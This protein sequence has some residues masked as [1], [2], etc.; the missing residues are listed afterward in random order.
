M[1]GNESTQSFSRIFYIC[2]MHLYHLTKEKYLG[3]ILKLGL[4]PCKKYGLTLKIDKRN[5]TKVF[6]TNNIS[7][8][9]KNHAGDTWCK[10]YN[11]MV[12]TIDTS[13]MYVT[14]V[15]YRDGATYTISDFEFVVD[16]VSPDKIIKVEKLEEF[17]KGETVESFLKV[18]NNKL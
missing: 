4:I 12:L 9:T 8:V 6:L 11:P 14:P 17:L 16:W 10:R 3:S 13:L 1:P 5:N 7:F 18:R 15:H 2:V